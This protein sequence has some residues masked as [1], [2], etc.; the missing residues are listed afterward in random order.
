MVVRVSTAYRKSGRAEVF[1]VGGMQFVALIGL[2]IVLIKSINGVTGWISAL[3]AF[4]LVAS[5]IGF[6]LAAPA[7]IVDHKILTIY[8]GMWPL[9]LASKFDITDLSSVTA[10]GT[11]VSIQ[12]RMGHRAT[13]DGAVLKA[14]PRIAKLLDDSMPLHEA[15]LSALADS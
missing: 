14:D 6:M 7:V 10:S 15:H 2:P 1:F 8:R 3:T 5:A 4:C 13:F 12:D 11:V 9:R